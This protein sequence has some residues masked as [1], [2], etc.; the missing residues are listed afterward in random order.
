[1]QT[2]E[3]NLRV[4]KRIKIPF[5]VNGMKV[6][7]YL[8]EDY[9][10]GV[11][12]Q[13]ITGMNIGSISGGRYTKRIIRDKFGNKKLILN[14]SNLTKEIFIDYGFTFSTRVAPSNNKF[15]SSYPLKMS[16]LKK[17]YKYLSFTTKVQNGRS[18]V[19]NLVN[20]LK[21]GYSS[22]YQVVLNIL[23]W[24]KLNIAHEP[25]TSYDDALTTYL[26]RK[27]N[28]NGLLN[29]ALMLL[30]LAK[31]PCRAVKGISIRKTFIQKTGN[32]FVEM[33]YPQGYYLW[34]EVFF[35]TRAWVPF[36][37]FSTYFFMPDNIIR[38]GV[39]NDTDQIKDNQKLSNGIIVDSENNFFIESM[40]SNNFLNTNSYRENKYQTV[41]LP[42]GKDYFFINKLW[43]DAN[44]N[45]TNNGK[46][47]PHQ[48]IASYPIFM[49]NSP[50]I[51][52][53]GYN[54][55]VKM[56][57]SENSLYAQKIELK[58]PFFL[59][60]IAVPLYASG[61]YPT[62]VIMEI[63]RDD[64]GNPGD[65]YARSY[66]KVISERN[67]GF[68]MKK[69][70]FKRKN[71]PFLEKSKYWIVVKTLSK[72]QIYWQGIFGNP[73]SNTKDTLKGNSGNW[74]TFCNMDFMFELWGNYIKRPEPK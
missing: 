70:F 53:T 51:K 20:N 73:I 59:D 39:G 71:W 37:I 14:F 34:I 44:N 74:N 3:A 38:L 22:V 49:F 7:L 64:N 24:I 30:R 4:T 50:S 9:T 13:K 33:S 25:A 12:I 45:I 10:N 47:L 18:G 6:E 54:T 65:L 15:T 23:K 2:I 62:N 66:Y 67:P 48:N 16:L 61:I 5:I 72:G 58:K 57:V 55:V 56:K 1:M 31:I 26:N 63:Y 8:P 69:F 32:K 21:R 35:P 19:A 41:V 36:D 52:K 43:K 28:E 68:S 17:Y 40:K 11:N 27:G 60:H 46:Y 29:L 42:S